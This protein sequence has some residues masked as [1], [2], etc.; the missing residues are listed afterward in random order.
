M[1]VESAAQP[2]KITL[3]SPDEY[4]E[5]LDKEV[6]A[7]QALQAEAK[8]I[9]SKKGELCDSEGFYQH[10]GECWS[11]ALQQVMNNGDTLKEKVQKLFIEKTFTSEDYNFPN[12][13]EGSWRI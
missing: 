3:E 7:I 13:I 4:L 10:S 11:D 6:S 12:T 5:Q 2:P 9:F 8:E 1:S